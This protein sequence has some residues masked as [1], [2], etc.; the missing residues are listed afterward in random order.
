[1]YIWVSN[2]T[3]GWDVFFDNLS[4]QHRQGP[5]LEENHY[6]PF[7]LTMQGISDKAIKTNYT[8]NR[9]RYNGIEYDS[10]FGLDEYE[11]RYR[12]L[13]P[14]TGRWWQIDPEAD[15]E[16][17]SFSPYASM[18]DDPV[19]K[20][21]P[22]GDADVAC[23]EF[24]KQIWDNE[25]R[26]IERFGTMIKEAVNTALDNQKNN[27]AAGSTP[28]QRI[29]SDGIDNP[30]SLIDGAE[31]VTL[32]KD[33]AEGASFVKDV[34]KTTLKFES[35]VTAVVKEPYKRPNN[36][37]TPAQRASVQGK[38]CAKCGAE[39]AKMVAGHKKALVKEHY[40]T[41]TIDK[42][43]MRNKDAVQPECTNCST[44]EGGEM[45][46]YSKHKKKEHGFK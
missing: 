9:Y 10:T 42:S 35:K 22:L 8:E 37:T 46:K 39:D 19:F 12:D 40:E 15:K 29:V 43:K 17:E 23:C 14:Q 3:Q 18:S 41:G 30:L 25:V 24:L 26:G 7:G 13:D 45:S 21:D 20:T 36:A 31:E 11:A 34:E 32:V 1:L 6:Y 28:L 2:E 27:W 33:V 5:L 16:R 38:P 44:K 4:V